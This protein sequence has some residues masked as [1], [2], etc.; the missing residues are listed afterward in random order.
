M[1][2]SIEVSDVSEK[3]IV[4]FMDSNFDSNRVDEPLCDQCKDISLIASTS[5]D[6]AKVII[7]TDRSG[8]LTQDI[9]DDNNWLWGVNISRSIAIVPT[10]FGFD[11]GAGDIEIPVWSL[12]A[13]IAGI[14]ANI[15]TIEDNGEGLLYT[16]TKLIPLMKTSF[17]SSKPIYIKLIPDIT[18][19]E[20]FLIYKGIMTRSSEGYD[21]QLEIN[22][23]SIRTIASKESNIEFLVF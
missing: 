16:F 9:V 6:L 8:K 21:Y 23:P 3:N 7:K 14:N 15:V 19:P 4:F 13:A 20:Y 17:E 1:E 12:S 18:K 10:K 11:D 5:E 2:E 22:D